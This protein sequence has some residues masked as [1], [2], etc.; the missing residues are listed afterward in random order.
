MKVPTLT[1]INPATLDQRIAGDEWL[2]VAILVVVLVLALLK[3]V[4]GEIRRGR[5]FR[6]RIDEIGVAAVERAIG[7]N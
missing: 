2:L 1:C 7:P 4:D 3:I 5:A 6:R